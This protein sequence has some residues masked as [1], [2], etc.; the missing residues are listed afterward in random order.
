[1]RWAGVNGPASGDPGTR[2][3]GTFI[4]G[5][6]R[7]GS[8]ML[9]DLL[10]RHAD[11]LS[12]SEFLTY[13]GT[14]ALLPGHVTGAR[15]WQRLSVQTPLYRRLFTPGTAPREFLYSTTNG[16]FPPGNVPPILATTLPHLTPRPDALF[17]ELAGWSTGQPVRSMAAHH[18]ALFDH[19]ATRQGACTWVERSG[20]SMMHARVLQAGFPDARFVFLHRD[21]RD[22]ALSLRNFVPARVIIW[23][24]HLFRRLGANPIA[25]AAPTGASWTLRALEVLFTPVFPLRRALATP[26]PLAACAGFWNEMMLDGLAQYDRLPPGRRM[27]L[28]YEQLC[29]DPAGHLTRLA[30]FIGV[31]AT[32]DWRDAVAPIPRRTP[33][34]WTELPAEDQRILSDRTE[35]ARAALAALS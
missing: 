28:G 5:T 1:M 4:L 19:L 9:S 13:L 11:V 3:P 27:L 25:S 8:T 16:R 29:A 32:R 31:D 21:G 15:Y 20:L 30:R 18:R 24:W 7:S 26:P 17:D 14:R 10:A 33:P 6:G 12:L 35:P 34:R 23:C 22:V 2:L